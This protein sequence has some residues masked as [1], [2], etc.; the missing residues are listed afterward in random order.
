MRPRSATRRR[1][2]PLPAVARA[3]LTAILALGM[4]GCDFAQATPT[5]RPSRLVSTP[6]PQ[7]T[8]AATE[9]D[10]VPTL[11]PDP[12]GSGPDLLDAVDGLADLASYRVAV[13]TRGLVPAVPSGGPVT[14]DSTLVQGDA[15]AARF[16]MAGVA[17]FAG[18]R[19]Q[20][21]VIG[22]QAWLR[23]GSG[24]WVKSAG[25]AA[26]FDAAFTTMSPID[27]V[28]GFEALSGA[29]EP[30]GTETRNGRRTI[31][32]RTADG[33]AG[34]TEAG[35][36]TGSVDAWFAASGGYLVAL[37]IDGTWDLDGGPTPVLLRI[38]VTRVDDPANRISPPV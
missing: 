9:I 16:S 32:Y 28:A 37:D 12:T 1:I 2:S 6:E 11:R 38:D 24:G 25:G 18:G 8:P 17:G 36:S 4:A 23:E 10:E 31:H 30:A 5:P 7:P 27:L 14:M 20:A 22:D 35:L 29:L 15:P 26:D 21:V 3:A 19:L 34:A 33:D 13:T